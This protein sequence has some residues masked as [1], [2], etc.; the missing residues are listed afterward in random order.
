MKK[1]ILLCSIIMTM[2]A[3][4]TKEENPL[5]SEFQTPYGVPCF[6][7]I[8][9]EHYV[10]AFKEA[11]AKQKEEIQ[12]I[13]DVPDDQLTFENTFVALDKSGGLL[14]RCV[15]VFFNVLETDGDEQMHA[16]S[17]EIMTMCSQASDDIMMDADLFK[18]LKLVYENEK[19]NLQGE[20]LRL[21]EVVYRSFVENGALLSDE[22]KERVKA[23]NVELASLSLQFAQNVQKETNAYKLFITDESELSGLPESV[24]TAAKDLAKENGRE[25][26][27]MFY[28]S[29]SSFIPVLQYA[30]NRALREKL[31]T[32]YNVRGNQNNEFDNKANILKTLALRQEKAKIFVFYNPADF[33]L[34]NS[35]AKTGKN[36][37][38]LLMRV[39]EPSV[40]QAKKEAK[41]LEALLQ[42]DYPNEKLQ[43]WDWWYYAEKLRK[44]KYDLDEAQIK[45][46]FEL[47]NVR[48]GAFGV[49]NKLYGLNFEKLEG[50]PIYNPEVE[51]FKVTDTENNL[52]GI[53]YTDYFPR[54]TKRAGA[55]MNNVR[56][57]HD[58][59]RPVIV[60]VGN[61]TKPTST[62]P[63]L[64][65]MDEVET[66]FH[67]FGH[68]LHGLMAQSKYK[69]LSG[70]N[71]P[72]DF[73]ELP[74]QF[75]E[76]Y[77]YDPDVLKTY[78]F[79]YQTGDLIPNELIEKINKASTFNQ[80]FVETELLC[81]S[82]LD[83]DY[84]LLK[85]MDALQTPEDVNKFEAES[86]KKMGMIDQI[87]VRYRSTFFNH[88]FTTG[89]EA[90]Y[91]S[92]TWSAVLD[93]DAFAAFKETGDI[94]NQKK[95]KKYKHLLE[96]GNNID[97]QENYL[98][99]R[100]KPAD[101]KYLLIRKGLL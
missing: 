11:I 38:D 89:Y 98:Q 36:A 29:R 17:E 62:D 24:K 68:A 57:Q 88:I 4:T 45:P 18:K 69:T 3:C 65:T 51:V 50:M 42:K 10:P 8:K 19:N 16:I 47:S 25:D 67:E 49:A 92:Y 54:S 66:L 80:G 27:W 58:T 14:S 86:M 26:A 41:E 90:G 44:A 46:Y 61:F 75:M 33:I 78:A 60:N 43:P 52:V 72:R 96:Q 48:K 1:V 85:N 79:H 22:Q 93:A 87:T 73:V 35:M 9:T 63:S 76:N 100:G 81:A 101:E 64:L 94:F 30:D 7:K 71:V 23:I 70:T 84:H 95:T 56:E 97:A 34:T 59:V 6:D 37:Y 5:L 31:H 91:Y 21:L 28:P 74:S 32:A 12:A 20:D 77:C 39:W 55:W 53:L 83:M 15:G 13:K 82:I 2:I 99:F 40:K